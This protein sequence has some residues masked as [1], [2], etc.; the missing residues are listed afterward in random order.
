MVFNSLREHHDPKSENFI[1]FLYVHGNMCIIVSFLSK[2]LI[3]RSLV[4]FSD[5]TITIH[6]RNNFKECREG[7]MDV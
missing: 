4:G 7:N 5:I 2:S 6:K 3:I 1:K